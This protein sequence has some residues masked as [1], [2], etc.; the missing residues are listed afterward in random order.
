LIR[1]QDGY[2]TCMD[3][4]LVKES[5]YFVNY[6][7]I[8]Y[9]DKNRQ[10]SA[11]PVFGTMIGDFSERKG[12]FEKLALKNDRETQDYK[13]KV[14]KAAYFELQYIFGV[15]KI[16]KTFF[17]DA[18]SLFMKN[19]DAIKKN[20]WLRNVNGGCS[21]AVY[22]ICKQNG[23]VIDF[24]LFKQVVRCNYKTFT[25]ILMSLGL[26]SAKT[27]ET[28]L[29][30]IKRQI[31][32]DSKIPNLPFTIRRIAC[33]LVE[34]YPIELANTNENV[35]AAS[36]ISAA[37]HLVY[38]NKNLKTV[39]LARSYEIASSC[40]T[41]R[42][43]KLFK[44]MI[45]KFQTLTKT[46]SETLMQTGHK[47][48]KGMGIDYESLLDK[49]QLKKL[50]IQT[51]IEPKVKEIKTITEQTEPQIQSTESKIE[52][53]SSCVEPAEVIVVSKNTECETN[54]GNCEENLQGE[55]HKKPN[56]RNKNLDAVRYLVENVK[57]GSGLYSFGLSYLRWL[58]LF[59]QTRKRSRLNF[60]NNNCQ[61]Y[62]DPSIPIFA[63][64]GIAES[65]NQYQYSYNSR[66]T[67]TMPPSENISRYVFTYK[68][69]P[70]DD[71]LSLSEM[72]SRAVINV[73]S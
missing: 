24:K 12:K 7:A 60:G 37:N 15:L 45:P 30:L 48:V 34:M 61:N 40:I 55:S 56:P 42:L 41:G 28:K 52:V 13:V 68:K 53:E 35:A 23:Y 54:L 19:W 9:E 10:V 47:L 49:K 14:R 62:T 58:S 29:M 65:Q 25:K 69:D 6:D 17:D 20:S 67:V 26:G 8:V 63:C 59:N 50:N 70:P 18:L 38:G 27:P 2:L 71:S 51:A 57:I 44:T 31:M 11:N 73:N 21:A 66:L 33:K 72:C 36:A 46:S 39:E 32:D 4:G 22:S 64:P 5:I 43:N 1:N 3:C 16:P